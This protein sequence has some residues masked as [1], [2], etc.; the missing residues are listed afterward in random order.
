MNGEDNMK[1]YVAGFLFNEEMNQVVL[2]KKT[3]PDW[4]KDFLNGVGGKIEKGENPY[5]TMKR[6]FE[7]EAGLTI[8][9]WKGF[10]EIS[11]KD[12]LCYFFYS[13]SNLYKN[14]TKSMT[15][16]TIQIVDVNNLFNEPVIENLRWLIPMCLDRSH[17]YCESKSKQF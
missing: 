11:G 12:W 14:G 5:M 4:Q 1:K 17:N 3:H 16:E 15:D 6:E 8:N 10:C 2:I 13:T 7:E 9:D